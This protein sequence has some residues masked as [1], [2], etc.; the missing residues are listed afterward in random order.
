MREG[1]GFLNASMYYLEK[2]SSWIP[3]LPHF[4]PPQVCGGCRVERHH[5][6]PNDSRWLGTLVF[7][8]PRSLPG[9]YLTTFPKEA[10]PIKKDPEIWPML[11]QAGRATVEEHYDINKLSD[12]LVETYQELLRQ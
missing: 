4:V 6:C 2:R 12:R 10:L 1:T 8:T 5:F 11:G 7:R 9:P 3:G